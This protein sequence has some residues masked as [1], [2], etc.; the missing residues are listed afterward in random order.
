MHSHPALVA[1][2]YALICLEKST[3]CDDTVVTHIVRKY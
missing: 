1:P 2:G 3:N